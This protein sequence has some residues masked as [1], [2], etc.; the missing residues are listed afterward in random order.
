MSRECAGRVVSLAPFKRVPA[1]PIQPFPGHLGVM[2]ATTLHCGTIIAL[3][4]CDPWVAEFFLGCHLVRRLCH[5]P[6]PPRGVNG[7]GVSGTADSGVVKQDKSSGGSV[8]TTKTRS[9]PQGVRMGSG[10]RPI[11]AAKGK[12]SDTEALCQPPP[13]CS[14]HGVGLNRCFQDFLGPLFFMVPNAGL[15]VCDALVE[16]KRG[17]FTSVSVHSVNNNVV[18]RIA[19]RCCLF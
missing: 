1:R 6:P 4:S 12:Q 5:P 2:F 17:S 16:G 3:E 9:G 8:D 11:G 10:D 13:P 19:T 14:T 7:M 15:G 18:P